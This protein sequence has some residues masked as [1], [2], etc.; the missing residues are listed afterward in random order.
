MELPERYSNE[1]G[2]ECRRDDNT[3]RIIDMY[4]H[5]FFSF[6]R[7]LA[8]PLTL[9]F[10]CSSSEDDVEM[11]TGAETK[12]AGDGMA[13][14]AGLGLRTNAQ[15]EAASCGSAL[16]EVCDPLGQD[17]DAGDTCVFDGGMFIC[18]EDLSGELGAHGDPCD[19]TNACD[20]GLSC[21][22]PEMAPN[23]NEAGCCSTFCDL[24]APN[25]CPGVNEG[26]YCV[27]WFLGGEPPS[28]YENVGVCALVGGLS[29]FCGNGV[30][31]E[32]EECDDGARVSGDGC[33]SECTAEASL[34]WQ[35]IVSQAQ[36]RNWW[37]F[38]EVEGAVAEDHGSAAHHGQH[39]NDVTVGVPALLG[40]AAHFGHNPWTCLHIGELEPIAGD[41][42]VE[43]VFAADGTGNLSTSVLVGPTVNSQV[44]DAVK[45]ETWSDSGK[46]GF[47]NPWDRSFSA[48]LAATPTTFKHVTFVGTSEGVSLYV[49]G[50]FTDHNAE[51]MQLTPGGIGAAWCAQGWAPGDVFGGLIDEVVIYDR[52]LTSTEIASHAAVTKAALSEYYECGNGVTEGAEE[53]DDGNAV[54]TDGCTDACLLPTCGDGLIWA[55]VESCDDGNDIGDDGCELCEIKTSQGIVYAMGLSNSGFTFRRFSETSQSWTTVAPEPAETV[56]TLTND[57]NCVYL[58]SSVTYNSDPAKRNRLFKYTPDGGAGQWTDIGPGPA[59][60]KTGGTSHDLLE[61]VGDGFYLVNNYSEYVNGMEKQGIEVWSYRNE[62]WSLVTTSTEHR[63]AIAGEWDLVHQ[64]LHVKERFPSGIIT[65]DTS[66]SPTPMTTVGTGINDGGNDAGAFS[67]DSF[68]RW[69]GSPYPIMKFALPTWNGST[70]G[71]VLTG[72]VSYS[73]WS[74][75]HADGKIYILKAGSPN[76]FYRYDPWSNSLDSTLPL[77]SNGDWVYPTLTVMRPL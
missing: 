27:P 43:A 63:T 24:S 30:I 37:R 75:D 5:T 22:T 17:C 45:A 70:T 20:P 23:C 50:S 62:S 74:T 65:L 76:V 35:A 16:M 26:E 31:G 11:S 67:R 14:A 3:E 69:V 10:A 25:T 57:G 60:I 2:D 9:A 21:I 48:P 49:N 46:M 52:A 51:T 41:W 38:D 4:R 18:V 55:G 68:F 42:T 13:P 8:L 61:W 1:A 39:L 34:E 36:P 40:R 54:N 73:D 71:T 66:E 58:L 53:C 7:S 59:Q 29:E 19:Y 32:G 28:G 33:S 72:P 64:R 12:S 15:C 44:N 47:T 77:P 6:K 56:T